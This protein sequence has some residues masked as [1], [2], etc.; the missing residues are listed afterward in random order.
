MFY[1][2]DFNSTFKNELAPKLIEA[3]NYIAELEAQIKNLQ[4]ENDRLKS[5]ISKG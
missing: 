5:I 2:K 4:S 1:D 3:G